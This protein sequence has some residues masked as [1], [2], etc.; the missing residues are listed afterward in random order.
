MTEEKVEY[1]KVAYEK[2]RLEL[3]HY[4]VESSGKNV[5]LDEPIVCT[6]CTPIGSPVPITH[7]LDRL[8]YEMR[9]KLEVE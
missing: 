5:N 3:K 9:K 8:F 1:D 7:V 6:M 4:V 2:V